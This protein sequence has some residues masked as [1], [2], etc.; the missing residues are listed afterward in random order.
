[1][2]C[3]CLNKTHTKR[4][5]DSLWK[6][7]ASW[8]HI[9]IHYLWNEW[10]EI[11]FYPG[12]SCLLLMIIPSICFSLLPLITGTWLLLDKCCPCHLCLGAIFWHTN[13]R[14]IA[15]ITVLCRTIRA[16]CN[17]KWFVYYDN[18]FRS[19]LSHLY[20]CM[21]EATAADVSAT[22]TTTITISIT[23]TNIVSLLML[24]KPL[25]LAAGSKNVIIL[26]LFLQVSQ[27]P[28]PSPLLPV[29]NERL[30]KSKRK[31]MVL[32]A[33]LNEQI[34]VAW[35]FVWFDKNYADAAYKNHSPYR[36][37]RVSR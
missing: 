17:D 8:H 7:L 4:K 14:T 11:F 13:N 2:T 31:E 34:K 36:F 29:L 30:D 35:L 21:W 33:R 6:S 1:M 9:I 5:S 10:C 19:I 27:A 26:I 23:T 25:L 28:P 22:T 37:K 24:Q 20:I 15:L 32:Y 3:K 18:V 12:V 16:V